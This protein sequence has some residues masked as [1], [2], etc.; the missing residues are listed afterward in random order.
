LSWK[1]DR[2]LLTTSTTLFVILLTFWSVGF[3]DLERLAKGIG[4]SVV[5]LGEMFPPNFSIL[6]EVTTALVESLQMAFAGTVLGFTMALPLGFIASW[7]L[8]GRMPSILSR[9]FLGIVRTIPALLWA[10]IFVVMFGLGPLPGTLGLAVYSLGYLGKLYYETID[11]VDP[12]V[13]EAVRSTGCSKIQ[14]IRHAYLPESA[15][16]MLSQLFF[17]FEYNVRASSILGFVGAGGVGFYM[18]GYIQTFQYQKLMTVIILTLA[19]VL[20]IDAVS[21]KVRS[22]HVINSPV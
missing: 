13:V 16:S 7:K 8:S 22:R 1:Q 21:S 6:P 5:F 14:L 2:T 12:E 9:L 19:V 20:I 3:F 10:L 17:M 15:N 11:S 18:L 4:N